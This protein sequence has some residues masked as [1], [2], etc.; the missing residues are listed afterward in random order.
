MS[1]PPASAPGDDPYGDPRYSV[2]PERNGPTRKQKVTFGTALGIAA[3]I[4]TILTLFLTLGQEQPQQSNTPRGGAGTVTPANVYPAN[5]QA[6][7][8]NSCE[9][10]GPQSVCECSLSW[11]QN[12]VGIQQFEQ[13]ETD[14]NQG[15][16]PADVA[17]VQAACG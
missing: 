2:P 5:V 7:F 8:L 9:A 6:N 16:Q 10:S 1:Y 17:N 11:F 14:V 3:S 4:A 13:D 15:F 12:H